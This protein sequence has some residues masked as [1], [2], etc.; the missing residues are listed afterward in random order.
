MVTHEVYKQVE[1]RSSNMR[2]DVGETL[3]VSR[4][5]LW[6]RA[7]THSDLQAWA[8]FQQSLEEKVLTWLHKHPGSEAACRLQSERHFVALAFE[9]L[10]QATVQG[11]VTCEMLS[12]VL[13]Y[14]RASLNGAILETLRDSKRP[15]AVS[16]IWPDEEDRF[17]RNELWDR[18]QARLSNRREQR[19]AYLLYHC[20]LEPTEI[21][22]CCPQEWSD[23]HEVA[24]LR[25]IILARLTQRPG[26][27]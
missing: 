8:A 9:R 15:G 21:V 2:Q 7:K 14:L 12:E 6:R 18:L 26:S 25:R 16:S 24:R 22:R 19:L 27:P 17:D 3:A 1:T 20:G 23:V 10:R 13:V 4:L 11:Q 5:E